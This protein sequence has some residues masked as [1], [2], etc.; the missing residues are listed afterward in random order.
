MDRLVKFKDDVLDNISKIIKGKEKEIELLIVTFLSG[1]HLL[2][3]DTSGIG[4]SEILKDFTKILHLTFNKIDFTPDLLPM[5]ISGVNFYNSVT[6]DFQFKEGP[7]FSN[8]V[9]ANDINKATPMTQSLLLEAMEEKQ[10]TIDGLTRQLPVPFMVVST[11][12]QLEST[13]IFPLPEAK[14]DRF[15]MRIKLGDSSREKGKIGVKN[16]NDCLGNLKSIIDHKE[17]LEVMRNIR[18]INIEDNV[19]EYLIEIIEETRKSKDLEFGIS[20]RASIDLYKASRAFAGINGRNHII[21]DD[22]K[23][24]APYV[25]NHRIVSKEIDGIDQSTRFIEALVNKIE[26]PVYNN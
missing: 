23:S 26:I 10:I 24:M 2:L 3:G 20:P 15:F 16:N 9:L 4:N 18:H 14:L 25:L 19:M 17:L 7:L 13:G 8:V 21:P 6:G 11:Q 1:G 12:N 5:N 22:I